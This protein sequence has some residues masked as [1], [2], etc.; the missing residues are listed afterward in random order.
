MV[1]VS[2]NRDLGRDESRRMKAQ[3]VM[4]PIC[5]IPP[6]LT[7]RHES[8]RAMEAMEGQR[9]DVSDALLQQ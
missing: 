1:R 2:G 8:S 5:T 3:S 4:I 7:D 9:K 6:L